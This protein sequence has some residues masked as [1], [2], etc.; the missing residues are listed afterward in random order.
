[1]AE[2]AKKART[3]FLAAML[4]TGLNQ[5]KFAEMKRNV[6]NDHVRGTDSV[7]QTYEEVI[8]YTDAYKIGNHRLLGGGPSSGVA[9]YQSG[10]TETSDDGMKRPTILDLYQVPSWK[11][12]LWH[13][14]LRVIA[15]AIS[16]EVLAIGRKKDCP[17]RKEKK[18][19]VG[20]VHMNVGPTQEEEEMLEGIGFHQQ[21]STQQLVV[22]PPT[23]MTLESNNFYVDRNSSYHQ[24]VDSSLL[25]NI[26][27][28]AMT[29]K[30][31]C[32]A[33]TSYATEKRAGFRHVS[34]VGGTN[35]N[36]EPSIPSST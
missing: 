4:F 14:T 2:V 35:G 31:D 20:Q 32:N 28:Q 17:K 30:A 26:E 1:M 5:V 16:V 36:C 3:R 18:S 12:V 7:P 27:T 15:N 19:V 10:G 33:G 34:H 25:T 11:M 29:L 13:P 6:H 9:F 22:A 24:C 8:K 21:Q 23:R